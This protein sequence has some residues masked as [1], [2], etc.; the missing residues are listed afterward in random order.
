MDLTT[1]IFTAPRNGIYFFSFSGLADFPTA[2]SEVG[3]GVILYLNGERI[4]AGYVE[5]SNTVANQNSPLTV[6]STLN[7]KSGDQVWMEID[8]ISTETSLNDNSYNHNNHF[9]GFMLEE[10]IVAS[11]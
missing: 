7:L 10:E 11:L 3:L 4:G 6:Q 8:V 5:E 9:T 1:G 2:S